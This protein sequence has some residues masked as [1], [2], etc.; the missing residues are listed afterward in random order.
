[1][2]S[3][4]P[5]M[6]S[7]L[8]AAAA[9]ALCSCVHPDREVPLSLTIDESGGAAVRVVVGVRGRLNV[10]Y[11]GLRGELRNRGSEPCHVAVYEHLVEPT[12]DDLPVL[13]GSPAPATIAASGRLL[14]ESLL[15][16]P[17]DGCEYVFAFP[18]LEEGNLFTLPGSDD[19]AF[20]FALPSEYIADDVHTWISV[21][22]CAAPDVQVD[23]GVMYYDHRVDETDIALLWPL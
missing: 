17:S 21:A 23:L 1:M 7:R 3:R 9:A 12:P 22:T 2:H 13:D 14:I 6:R 8:L 16:P 15:P 10:A 4:S 5:S 19:Y 18:A 11:V 20:G